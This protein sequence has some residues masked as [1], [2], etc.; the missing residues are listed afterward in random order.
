LL[1]SR[2]SISRS[3]NENVFFMEKRDIQTDYSI[4]HCDCN[5][6]ESFLYCLSFGFY[7]VLRKTTSATMRCIVFLLGKLINQSI[8]HSHK[9]VKLRFFFS[10]S[11]GWLGWHMWD[12]R[13]CVREQ[14][15]EKYEKNGEKKFV[16][17]FWWRVLFLF[18]CQRFLV[19]VRFFLRERDV[20]WIQTTAIIMYNEFSP[21]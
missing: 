7:L 6:Y 1:F 5:I 17:F 19:C 20:T 21:S 18:L 2:A 8:S 15:S 12:C 3:H 10:L 13:A 11:S 9:K 4:F 16:I 14:T